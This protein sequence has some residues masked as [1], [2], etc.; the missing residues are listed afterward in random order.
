MRLPG[1]VKWTVLALVGL[2][3]AAGVA[4]AASALTSQQIGISAESI[5]AGDA[6]APHAGRDHGG[7]S[8]NHGDGGTTGETTP[9][10]PTETTTAPTEPETEPPPETTPSESG[11][12]DS[13][14]GGGGGSDDHG[15]GG[16]GSDD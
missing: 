12:D 2:A 3:I 11:G 10:E 1:A 8:S 4:L 16:H 13:G 14:G 6:L 5:S 15:S 7:K 9:S